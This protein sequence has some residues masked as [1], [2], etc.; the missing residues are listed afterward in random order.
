MGY[1]IYVQILMS[2]HKIVNKT[3]RREVQ[4]FEMK[5]YILN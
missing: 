4:C 1:S 3:L 2:I 5:E